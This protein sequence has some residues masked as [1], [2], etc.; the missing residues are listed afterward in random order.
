MVRL[1]WFRHFEP[2]CGGDCR[3]EEVVVGRRVEAERLRREGVNDDIKVLGL[4]PEWAVFRNLG[5]VQGSGQTAN[6]S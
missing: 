2:K 5:S 3:N 6:P 4:Q 1:R